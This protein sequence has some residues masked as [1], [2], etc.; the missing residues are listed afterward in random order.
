MNCRKHFALSLLAALLVG[1]GGG[2]GGSAPV[3][4]S[5]EGFWNGTATGGYTTS[6]AVLDNGETWGL[7]GSGGSLA[8]ALYG[9]T[10]VNGTALSGTGTSF[11]FVTRTS[12]T[13]SYSG[14]VTAKSSLSLTSGATTFA[15]SYDSTYDQAATLSALAGTYTGYALTGT[16]AAQTT[17][18]TVTSG[19]LISSS[20]VSGNLSCSTSG[21]ATPRAGG[22]NVYNVQLTFTG[23]YCALGNGTTVSG[24]GTFNAPNK[25]VIV[26]TLNGGKTDGLMFVGQRP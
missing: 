25:Q 17:T 21:T 12:G 16:I 23:N 5:A 1:C 15:A 2:G 4:G 22:K 10:V 11:N 19:G 26:M 24:V 6:I 20:Y 3:S 14:T 9:Q 8:G 7:Y 13:G 18:V